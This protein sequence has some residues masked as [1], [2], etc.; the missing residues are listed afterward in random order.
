MDEELPHSFPKNH[1]VDGL[2]LLGVGRFPM[3]EAERKYWPLLD[4][5]AWWA[6]AFA[7]TEKDRGDGGGGSDI[8]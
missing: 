6:L 5:K 3:V 2:P 1:S 4:N 7:I 8:E